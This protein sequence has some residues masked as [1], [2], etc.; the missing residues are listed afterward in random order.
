MPKKERLIY[1]Y[2]LVLTLILV[3]WTDASSS[4]SMIVR[5]AFM[6]A[7]FVPAFKFRNSWLPA[8]FTCFLSI[9]Q[10]GIS[11]SYLPDTISVYMYLVIIMYVLYR[12]KV[13]MALFPKSLIIL[14]A[15]V[16]AVDLIADTTIY[17]IFYALVITCLIVNLFD[18]DYVDASSKLSTAYIIVTMVLCYYFVFFRDTFAISYNYDSGLERVSWTDPNY[19]GCV[20]GM[21]AMCCGEKLIDEELKKYHRLLL[22]LI[23]GTAVTIMVMNASRGALL[24]LALGVSVLL[25]KANIKYYY[26]VF[27]VIS[28]FV[29]IVYLYNNSYFD[30]LEYRIQNDETGSG[31]STIWANRLHAFFSGNLFHQIFGYG[32]NATMTLGTNTHIGC[33]SDYVAFL[34]EYGYIGICLFLNT[35]L[36]PVRKA[37]SDK[38]RF[39]MVLAFT[40]YL[41]ACC[42]T[43]EPLTLGRIPYYMFFVLILLLTNKSNPICTQK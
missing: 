12:N 32:R 34:V 21:G 20:I 28:T 10:Y 39:P 33:H 18:K 19:L 5:L 24:A 11:Y 8:V 17:H 6:T 7:T 16:L 35:L 2:Y 38:K 13:Q 25:Y 1:L 43:L 42:L 37:L 30:L 31:R 40:V 14:A 4:P 41:A 15:Y 29:F 23:F 3:S 27:I 9:C 36:Y 22:F 26:K